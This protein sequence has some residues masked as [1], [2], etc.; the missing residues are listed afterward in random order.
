MIA[1]ISIFDLAMILFYAVQLYVFRTTLRPS[2]EPSPCAKVIVGKI[3]LLIESAQGHGVKDDHDLL[4]WPLFMAAVEGTVH[5]QLVARQHMRPGKFKAQLESV[6]QAQKALGERVD[7][8][9]LRTFMFDA[10]S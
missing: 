5:Q 1:R 3:L 7:I 4:Q 2:D 8:T 9:T 10:R 6:L